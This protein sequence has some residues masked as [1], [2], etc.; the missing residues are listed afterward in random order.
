MNDIES[1]NY[2]YNIQLFKKV[3]CLFALVCFSIQIFLSNSNIDYYL[4]ILLLLLNLISLFYCF[5]EK[6]FN[7]FPLSYSVIF[8]SIFCIQGSSIFFKTFELQSISSGLYLPF[9][10][11]NMLFASCILLICIHFIYVKKNYFSNKETYIFKFNKKLGLFKINPKFLFTTGVLAICLLFLS[12][13]LY[14]VGDINNTFEAGLPLYYT[15]IN[16]INIFYLL[17]FILVFSKQLFNS[18]YKINFYS[19]LI[20]S[21]IILITSIGSNRRHLIFFGIINILII[22]F[23][24]FLLGKIKFNK[25]S[26]VKY[27]LLIILFFSIYDHVIK[28]NYVYV[29]ERGESSKRTFTENITSFKNSLFNYFYSDDPT[30]YIQKVDNILISDYNDYYNNTLFNRINFTEYADNIFYNKETFFSENDIKEIRSYQIGRI[31][32]I[33]PQPIINIFYDGFDKK[34]YQFVNIGS[35]INNKYNP[36][37]SSSNDFSSFIAEAYFMFGYL[38]IFVIGIFSIIYFYIIDSFFDKKRGIFSVIILLTLFHFTTYMGV[39]F[40]SPSLDLLIFNFRTLFQMIII[41]KIMELIYNIF[42]QKKA[43]VN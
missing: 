21:F 8:L 12:R 22:F 3:Y 20:F 19:L 41:Y 4:I 25:K 43:N 37:Y 9:F 26:F 39:I 28:F 35:K 6:Y 10:S 38:F 14:K 27:T 7:Q 2:K 42:S 16:G 36:F 40:G 23:I 13:Y 33:I 31:I 17:P 24:L 1:D 30:Y 29:Y 18:E 34:K 11:S 15:V 5:N 32:G